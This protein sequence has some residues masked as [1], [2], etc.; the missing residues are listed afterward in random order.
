MSGWCQY[1]SWDI[2]S[3]DFLV[4]LEV[5]QN[6]MHQLIKQVLES[7]V[8]SEMISNAVSCLLLYFAVL[9][10]FI[11]FHFVN[12]FFKR[13][14]SHWADHMV[15]N[16]LI[17]DSGFA[18][19][20]MFPSQSISSYLKAKL[21]GLS[22]QAQTSCWRACFCH[23]VEYLGILFS[24]SHLLFLTIFC[25]GRN[26]WGMICWWMVQE[27]D[28]LLW[29]KHPHLAGFAHHNLRMDYAAVMWVTVFRNSEGKATA[30]HG[31]QCSCRTLQLNVALQRVIRLWTVYRNSV[32]C[33][34]RWFSHVNHP[35]HFSVLASGSKGECHDG[36]AECMCA[37]A[38]K[39]MHEIECAKL[40]SSS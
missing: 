27:M 11:D 31:T 33:I 36:C 13:L 16:Q 25:E 12:S 9:V 20:K 7:A 34:K 35:Y 29:L 38:H 17:T 24:P 3:T 1:R 28:H 10:S 19:T 32:L 6:V 40:L 39:P 21:G 37:H 18:T 22:R 14:I 23:F 26:W 4:S 15:R 30:V 8:P 5:L 2:L